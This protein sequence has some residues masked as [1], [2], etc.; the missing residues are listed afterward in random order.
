MSKKEYLKE[1]TKKIYSVTASEAVAEELS[2][3]LD[4]KTEAYEA[5][6]IASDIAEEKAIEDMGDVEA[7]AD[8]FGSIHNTAS[9][10]WC[11]VLTLVLHLGV[12]AAGWYGVQT[13]V[14]KDV[15]LFP[16][17]PGALALS[18]SLML[19]DEAVCLKRRQLLPSVFSFLRLAATAVFQYCV[20]A[21][22][23]QA[24][25]GD[26]SLLFKRLVSPYLSAGTSAYRQP[27]VM[28]AVAV[29]TA[30][31]LVGIIVAL[32]WEI[33]TRTLTVRSRDNRLRR[34]ALR[35]TRYLA[36]LLAAITV[37]LAVKLY[38]D[39]R[40][41]RT[42]YQNAYQTALAL[43]DECETQ[44]QVEH[45]LKSS[46]L[47][48]EP[49]YDY[50]G[51]QTGY[52]YKSNYTS[53][54][55]RYEAV[56]QKDNIGPEAALHT[57]MQPD[58]TQ[59]GYTV[60]LTADTA[61]LE[62]R[63]DGWTLGWL[64]LDEDANLRLHSLDLTTATSKEQ[65]VHYRK[66]IPTELTGYWTVGAAWDKE[67]SFVFTLSENRFRY[68]ETFSLDYPSE[69]RL[70]LEEKETELIALLNTYP[71]ADDAAV[72]E[73]TGAELCYETINLRDYLDDDWYYQMG[74]L[75]EEM[76]FSLFYLTD[77]IY[78][79]YSHD[80]DSRWRSLS[81]MRDGR[82]LSYC[83]LEAY[84]LHGVHRNGKY[85]EQ[86][87]RT[88]SDVFRKISCR[89]CYFDREGHCYDNMRY[90]P[91]YT[92]DGRTFWIYTDVT[93]TEST[94]EYDIKNFYLTDR[95]KLFYDARQCYIDADGYLVFD[96]ANS[97]QQGEGQYYTA[98]GG[99]Q[100][101]RA[102]YTSWDSEGNILPY[103]GNYQDEL[104]LS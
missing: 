13:Y 28:A 6:S 76:T 86:D 71:E 104:M 12:L 100:V 55:V 61:L 87:S 51:E 50:A 64:R 33:K 24:V 35:V 4:E 8:T 48:F 97:F 83:V 17:L 67:V 73:L 58:G 19:A 27:V 98:P 93:K 81:L 16:V 14:G 23:D 78:F 45:F 79:E 11:D 80:E 69:E 38:T 70:W 65:Y 68:Q 56:K 39:Y 89:G 15:G 9:F 5:R 22:T 32:V 77:D 37:V 82:M 40:H 90:L 94:Q 101:T 1:A 2:S 91:Y 43:L 30:L 95:K 66:F 85:S 72:A 92:R 36:L 21:A 103:D 44:E 10:V 46:S 53:L 52:E 3:H 18:L 20:L 49:A 26:L 102:L 57:M 34:S 75:P 99:K 7:L 62:E 41:Y 84:D 88:N 74:Y 47:P 42:E 25:G 60:V 54:T 96:T 63:Y 31:Q 29:L 59:Y